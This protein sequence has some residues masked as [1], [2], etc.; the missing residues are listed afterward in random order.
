MELRLEMPGLQ[1]IEAEMRALPSRLDGRI[2]DAGLLAGARIVR[3]EAKAL[4]PELSV[5]DPRWQR[6]ALKRAIAATRIR[7]EEQFAAEAIVRVRKLTKRQIGLFSR[8]HFRA[9]R[10][11]RADPRDAFYWIFP[12]FGTAKMRATPFL[13]PAFETKKELAVQKAIEVIRE[14]LQL[15]LQKRGRSLEGFVAG[16]N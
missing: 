6:G 5:Q 16:L 13:R 12:E 14:R 15:E 7:P 9:G 3:D 10:L 1:A 8:R 2:L 11:R 4:A